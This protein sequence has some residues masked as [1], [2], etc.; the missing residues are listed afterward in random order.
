MNISI[1]GLTYQSL[2]RLPKNA[3]QSVQYLL[4][5]LLIGTASVKRGTK[6]VKQTIDFSA[7]P[8]TPQ[9]KT[10]SIAFD[11]FLSTYSVGCN[12]KKFIQITRPDN[13]IFYR[14]LLS[15]FSNFFIQTKNECHTAAFIFL[16]RTLER[17]SYSIP[18][19]YC[20]T[21]SDYINTFKELKSLLNPE[22]DGELGLFKRFLN[23][24]KF[25][26]AIKLD[27]TYT[28]NFFSLQGYQG[29]FFDLTTKR[30]TKLFSKDSTLSQIEI[31]F[32]EVPE[33]LK[34]LRN[35]FFHLRTG[36]GKSNIGMD[37]IFDSDEYFACLNPIFCSFLAIVTL[38]TIAKKYQ[39]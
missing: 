27:I 11:E 22:I 33:L 10:R 16:Y 30:Y 2:G 39:T 6:V 36:D 26:D 3:E 7:L 32:R 5:R 29:K 13:R 35:R 31:T 17:I 28:I 1:N 38:Q 18:L 19:L 9:S 14:D 34:T 20:S 4:V 37:E 23:E 12:S 15:E 8:S 24:G 21:Q 25:I